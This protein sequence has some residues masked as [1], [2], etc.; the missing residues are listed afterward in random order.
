MFS[1]FHLF[2]ELSIIWLRT[3]DN[4]RPFNVTIA[5]TR[6]TRVTSLKA[7]YPYIILA[8]NVKLQVDSCHSITK[9]KGSFN[10]GLHCFVFDFVLL[11]NY[12]A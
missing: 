12:Y 10:V 3:V 8:T 1:H 6:T 4:T 11:Q 2:L 9:P 7:I 5:I